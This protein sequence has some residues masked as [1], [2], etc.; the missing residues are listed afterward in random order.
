MHDRQGRAARLVPIKNVAQIS[1]FYSEDME[2]FL[3]TEVETP[4]NR[5]I[6]KLLNWKGLDHSERQ[7]LALYMGAMIKRVPRHR[8]FVA[9][10][11]P[12]VLADVIGNIRGQL[13]AMSDEG[14]SDPTLIARRL[15]EI[16]RISVAY[17]RE[18][19]PQLA[20]KVNTP[21]PS[22]TITAV[23]GSMTWR[24]L[25]SDG[26][27][28][29]VTT[30]NPAFFFRAGGFGLGNAVSEISFPLS[31]RFALHGSYQPARGN[32]VYLEVAQRTVREINRRLISDADRLV[33]YHERARWIERL[34][35]K[36]NLYLSRIMWRGI[37]VKRLRC[38]WHLWPS[39]L[40]GR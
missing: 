30:D 2:R 34:L 14:H 6:D 26:P 12:D 11:V 5:A 20:E 36:K 35:A 27:Q 19:P 4:G 18:L 40:L 7:Q 37:T 22:E 33:F 13:H 28:Y 3:A 32:L 16:D 17:S 21:L 23:L 1:K 31:T 29:F 9:G 8:R 24:V 39:H 15:G 38:A 25:V 10:M